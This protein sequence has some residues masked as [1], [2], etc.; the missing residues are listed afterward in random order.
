[1]K[2]TRVNFF[3]STNV[4]FLYDY[5]GIC[6][7]IKLY[8]IYKVCVFV[9]MDSECS[10]L[11]HCGITNCCRALSH[12]CLLKLQKQCSVSIRELPTI[13]SILYFQND[14]GYQGRS[15]VRGSVHLFNSLSISCYQSS[16]SF[17]H[18]RMHHHHV[19]YLESLQQ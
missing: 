17:S 18:V 1:M 7:F 19:T 16:H 11:S 13:N 10:G 3:K 9:A 4:S 8:H 12:F 15:E 14:T 2:Q 5:Q 6:H